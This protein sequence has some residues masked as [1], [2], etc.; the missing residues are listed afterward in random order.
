VRLAPRLIL[1]IGFLAA[2]SSAGLGLTLREDRRRD[3]TERF[4]SEV[5]SA[6][7]RVASEASR[8]AEA[9]RKLIAGACQAGE[10]VDR[11]L[12]ALDNGELDERRL[13][14]AALVPKEREAF[15]LD[16]LLLVSD[17]GDILGADPRTLLGMPRA[18]LEE[19]LRDGAGDAPRWRLRKAPEPAIAS[20]CLRHARAGRVVGLLGARYLG[21][22]LARLGTTAGVG[23][24]LGEAKAG[25]GAAEARCS[26]T[27]PAGAQMTIVVAKSK[28]TLDSNLARIDSTI[29]LAAIA[30]TGAALLLAVLLARSVGRPIE[31]LARE[32]RKVA[33]DQARPLAVRGS[34]ELAELAQA[35]DRM[36]DDLGTTRRRLAAA[37]RIAAWRE[38]ARRVAHEVKNPLAPIRAA[39]ETLRRLRARNDPAFEEYFDEAT[40]TVLD[41]VH[42]ISTIVTEFTRFARLPAPRPQDVDV[43]EVVR[44]VVQ[45]HRAAAGEGVR[46]VQKGP[47]LLPSIRADRDQLVQVL[48]NL[49]Q[50]ALDAVKERGG[51]ITVTTSAQATGAVVAHVSITVADDGPGV[52]AEMAAHLFEPYAT[53]KT[54]GTGLGLAIAQRIAIEHDGELAYLGPASPPG[55]RPV[56]ACF[57]LVLP[58]EGPPLSGDSNDLAPAPGD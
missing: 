21:P 30:S 52:P 51:E 17:P 13:A 58:L 11:A 49:V 4:D 23:V 6:C 15:D 20:R 3:E 1:S 37:S 47:R 36:L 42:R 24:S 34:G 56:G 53:T 50:N 16:E 55:G 7:A 19:A 12:V 54:N 22:L 35:F 27:D 40:R 43:D 18:A 38:V 29:L 26:L 33:T 48:T 5:R 44:Q 25:T 39:V 10:L 45:L 8:Q 46:I 31:E 2:A 41:E 32:A 9:D 14:L 57:R 28:A